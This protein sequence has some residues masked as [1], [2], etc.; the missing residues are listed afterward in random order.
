MAKLENIPEYDRRLAA[1]SAIKANILAAV[2]IKYES[3]Q[4]LRKKGAIA[5]HFPIESLPILLKDAVLAMHDK[6]QA[7]I[8]ICAQT[9]LAVSNLAVQAHA[10][11]M[12]PFGQIR[13]ISC[14][15]LTI[16][17]SGE[18]KTSCD[19][20]ALK[21]LEEYEAKLK[22]QYLLDLETWQNELAAYNS[23]RDAIL[24]GKN[25]YSNY[26][27]KKEALAAIGK[28]PN[29]PLT[30]LLI[31]PD[32]TFEGLCKLMKEGMP[33]LG[34]FS[35]EGG[36]FIGGYGMKDDNKIRTAAALSHVWDG[37]AIKRVRNG[38]GITIL[39]GRRLSMHLMAQP[40]IAGGFLADPVLKDQGLLSRILIAAPATIAG[41]RSR[42]QTNSHSNV[43]L[44]KFQQIIA[45]ILNVPL[46]IETNSRNELA[47][48]TITLSEESKELF[49]TFYETIESKLLCGEEFDHIKDFANKLPEHALR[50]ATTL[51]LID[52]IE[53][54]TLKARYL[55]MGIDLSN[56]YAK[57]VARLSNREVIDYDLLLAEKLL[58]WLHNKWDD[59]YISL[60]DIYQRSINPI[61]TRSK[62]LKIIDILES[63]HW[64]KRSDREMLIKG[65]IRKDVWRI[66]KGE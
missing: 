31:C 59:E 47:P 60:P 65:Q 5:T 26:N 61:N 11:I 24:K 18:R 14:F 13:P 29:P 4:P 56:Y 17:E 44:A 51:A 6:I 43:A 1:M 41:T 57:E 55:Q 48:R 52:N 34:V 64:L 62:A 3:P 58:N 10:N 37:K 46:P 63:H 36:Q 23:V 20:E 49:A 32:P 30:P 53:E 2:P 19:N 25:K 27:S 33:T 8:A 66:V 7:P 21:V 35:S 38:D 12:M 15:F 16:A 9:I 50:L 42:H 40:N 45:K 28:K 39:H 22:E 54:T